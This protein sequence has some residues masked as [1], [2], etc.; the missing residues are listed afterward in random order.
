[1]WLRGWSE[2]DYTGEEIIAKVKYIYR[3]ELCRE[4]YC[5]MA[6]EK[7]DWWTVR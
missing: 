1:M 7:L 6:I 4:G 5:I 3:E 2:G